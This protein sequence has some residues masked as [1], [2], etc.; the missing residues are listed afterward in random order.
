MWRV[1]SR[2]RGEEGDDPSIIRHLYDLHELY[3][4]FV[5]FDEI[6]SETQSRYQR[7]RRRGLD[8]IPHAYQ[9]ALNAAICILKDDP[10]YREEYNQYALNMCFGKERPPDFSIALKTLTALHD[11]L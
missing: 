7:D 11:F 5:N 10:F 6:V 8:D 9:E 4:Q 2:V 1:L 3:G